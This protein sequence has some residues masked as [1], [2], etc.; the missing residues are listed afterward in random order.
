M[1]NKREGGHAF[2]ARKAR[3][4]TV[5]KRCKVVAVVVGD[6]EGRHALAEID[7]PGIPVGNHGCLS[8]MTINGN[9]KLLGLLSPE[10][11][12]EGSTIIAPL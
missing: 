10:T 4:A 7:R 3:C 5:L 8:R 11:L 9:P 6:D 2:A 12:G 1:A